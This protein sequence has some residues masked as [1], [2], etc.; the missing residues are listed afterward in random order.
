MRPFADGVRQ[1]LLA[2]NVLARL[3]GLDGTEGVPV[4]GR[5]DDDGI[6]VL[7]AE[8]LAEVCVGGAAGERA[9]LFLL[10]VVGFDLL[11]GVVPAFGDHVADRHDL[12]AGIAEEAAE[13]PAALR[14]DAD[15]AER[16]ALIGPGGVGAD[17]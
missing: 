6:D 16:D 7:A 1:R 15:E 3:R 11:L 14:A 5:G 13:V 12:H 4:V 9:F 17:G 2:V 8:E 10:G